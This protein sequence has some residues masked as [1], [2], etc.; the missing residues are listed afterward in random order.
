[1]IVTELAKKMWD[2][3]AEKGIGVLCRPWV[4][5]RDGMA[6]AKAERYKKLIAAQTEIDV[7]KMKEGTLFIDVEKDPKQLRS[8]LPML[9]DDGKIDPV[10]NIDLL[11]ESARVSDVVEKVEDSVNLSKAIMHAD[12][13]LAVDNDDAP[14][15][16]V[17]D[18]W[19]RRW[20][21]NAS[22]TST[23]ELQQ[24]WGSI[25]AGEI[26][27]PGSYSLRTVEF[28][29]NLSKDEAI[30]IEI[31]YKFIFLDRIIRGVEDNDSNEVNEKEGKL[32]FKFLNDMQNL[33]LIS[34][35]EA[36][37]L[38][39][40]YSSTHNEKFLRHILYNN[41]KKVLTIENEDKEKKLQL[42]VYLLTSL[43]NEMMSLCQSD[44]NMPYLNM[45][46]NKIKEN[47]FTVSVSDVLNTN[48]NLSAINTV[49]V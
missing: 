38:T 21:E 33:G 5:Q 29:K 14:T 11:M 4:I 1:M 42:E 34:G 35:V 13:I 12:S 44:I 16:D 28:I 30:N 18:D 43:G 36:I 47:G 27:E 45:V 46:I 49:I 10:I 26:K 25:L 3:L 22:K 41:K 15:K 39:T 32:S 9:P 31:L 8:M 20:R 40:T 7:Q 19:L 24:I 37:G 6:T 23:I 17:N 48:G 2:S